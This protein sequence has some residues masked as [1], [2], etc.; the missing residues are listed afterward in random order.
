ME[1]SDK[2]KKELQAAVDEEVK[3]QTV[4]MKDR[5]R[6]IEK[7]RDTAVQECES[8]RRQLKIERKDKE[9]ALARVESMEQELREAKA[10]ERALKK[11]LA[12]KEV[13]EAAG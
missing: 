7:T 6:G 13:V 3:R 9:A 1:L 12:E 10:S 8:V 5:L 4:K 2:C 11:A